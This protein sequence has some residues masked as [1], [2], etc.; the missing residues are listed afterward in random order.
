MR[1]LAVRS[2]VSHSCCWAAAST[3]SPAAGCRRTSIP[4]RSRRSTIRPS[5]PDVSKELFDKMHE[6]LQRKLGVRDAPAERADAV[7]RGIITDVRRRRS[8][9]VQRESAAGASPRGDTSRSRSR[10][11]SSTSRTAARS[12]TNKA[13]R[14]EA[15]YNE[16][17]EPE[18]RKQ[19]IAKLVQPDRG[20]ECRAIGDATPRRQLGGLL[21]G[22]LVIAAVVYFGVSAGEAYWRFYQSAT[23]C[24][25]KCVSPGTT[26]TT[27]S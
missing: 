14:G 6:E 10:S 21:A 3:A 23:T 2:V 9:G 20:R 12:F 5:S 25:R 13:L 16:R 11:T 15:D 4:W 22:L 1:R 19:A 27:R 26:R 24:S 18:G 17:A 7:V 8:G